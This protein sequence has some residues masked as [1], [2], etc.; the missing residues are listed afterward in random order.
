MSSGQSAYA[1]PARTAFRRAT[2]P[3]PAR[4]IAGAGLLSL[5][6]VVSGLLTYAFL[7]LAARTLGPTDY[8]RI[9]VLWGAM[10]IVAIVLFR[11]LEQTA[12]RSISDRRVRG[13]EVR[14]VIGSVCRLAA[15]L[16]AVVG[17]AAAAG[18]S[19]L[20][21]RL[22]GGDSTLM[23]LLVVGIGFYG[24]SYVVRG[25]VGG[26]LWF[27]G[28]GINLVA[29]GLGRLLLALPLVV[30]ASRGAAGA[31]IAGAGL[32]GALAP[33]LVGR[34]RLRP[35]LANG[36]GTPF[37]TRQATRFA[38]PAATIAA[39]DQLLINGAPLLVM[40]GGGTHATRAAGVAFAATMLVRAPVYVFQGVA[41]ALLPNLTHLNA[42]DGFRRLEREV[43]RTARLLVG[44]A[45]AVAVACAL[46]GPLG[47]RLLY[48]Q[49]YRASRLVFAALGIGV[50][51]YLLAATLSQALLAID[52][53]RR[54]AVAWALS[55]V[56]LVGAYAAL[57]GG[58]VTR[59]AV[60]FAVASLVLLLGLA[61]LVHRGAR[62]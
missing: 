58:E 56:V 44:A 51:L 48:G 13:D 32:L 3:Q 53:G 19:Q 40:L 39:A 33:L 9:G 31:A 61:G 38:L 30:V 11:P 52:A 1:Q 47:M 26:V 24:L 45:V 5:A 2:A 57:P 43:A 41:A 21:G 54:A 59:V 6:M 49:E 16:I 14:T 15:L 4:A 8:G 10:F 7:V 50:A 46:G 12:S 60:A 29:D 18:W 27:D 55:G 22:F 62:T 25:L 20:A 35:L 34:H 28:Y 17:T 23:A 42:T 37:R 36:G